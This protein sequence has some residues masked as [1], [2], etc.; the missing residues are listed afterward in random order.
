MSASASVLLGYISGAHGVKG[1]VKVFSYTQPREQIIEYSPWTLD[2]GQTVQVEAGGA[3]GSTVIAK[4]QGTDDRDAA[5]RLMRKKIRV[6]EA[7]LPELGDGE[8]YWFQLIGMRVVSVSGDTLGT[9]SEM[10]ETG[11]NDVML[12]KLDDTERLIP[13]VQGAVVTNIDLQERLIT[14]DWEAD[15]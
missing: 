1:W 13:F 6:P 4:L 5:L 2:N 15:F 10:I 7:S 3:H 9:L 14:V 8:Y 11:A 12:V